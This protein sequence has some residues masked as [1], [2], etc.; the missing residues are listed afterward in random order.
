[1]LK[2]NKTS[3]LIVM[4]I[5]LTVACS[6]T[7]D[8]PKT[9][10][11]NIRGTE[12]KLSALEGF[13]PVCE[14]SMSVWEAVNRSLSDE[15]HLLA[16]FIKDFG[17]ESVEEISTED[18]YPLMTIGIQK[19]VINE[20]ISK[21]DFSNLLETRYKPDSQPNTAVYS[22]EAY[23]YSGLVDRTITIDDEAKDLEVIVVTC[24]AL[25]KNKYLALTLN[26]E[27]KGENDFEFTRQL[28]K[29]WLDLIQREN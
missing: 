21:D 13:V 20:S 25:I 28:A 26:N 4:L 2:M 22:E 19:S 12:I 16:C 3:A 7:S 1:M 10:A 11:R 18:M 29:E 14:R 5:G 15:I 27:L 6:E 23:C 8:S 17:E 24:L 9:V